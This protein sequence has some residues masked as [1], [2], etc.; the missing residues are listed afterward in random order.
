MIKRQLQE[1]E[2]LPKHYQIFKTLRAQIKP[3]GTSDMS[4]SVFLS[5]LNHPTSR[6]EPQNLTLRVS[7]ANFSK[8]LPSSQ[9]E[10]QSVRWPSSHSSPGF[11]T[12]LDVGSA[13]RRTHPREY[14]NRISIC[15]Q[16]SYKMEPFRKLVGG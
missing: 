2:C 14:L 15:A 10:V 4:L 12:V 1:K 8:Q 3:S 11:S 6:C 9:N 13:S 5:C 7:I 16:S